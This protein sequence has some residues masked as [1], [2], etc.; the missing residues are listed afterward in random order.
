MVNLV[1]WRMTP[2][3][4]DFLTL[5]LF[6]TFESGVWLLCGFVGFGRWTFFLSRFDPGCGVIRDFSAS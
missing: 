2:D 6:L 5:Y 1:A 3:P 4:K